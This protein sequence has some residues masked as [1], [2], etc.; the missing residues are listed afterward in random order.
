MRNRISGSGIFID[1]NGYFH[2]IGVHTGGLGDNVNFNN[3]A[4]VGIKYFIDICK[5]NFYDVPKLSSEIDGVL[6]KYFNKFK[7]TITNEDIISTM[8]DI[9]D[10]D[11]S[12]IINL[13]FCDHSKKCEYQEFYHKCD[14]F[15]FNLLLIITLIKYFNPEISLLEMESKICNLKFRF[16][17][18]E[19][20]IGDSPPI[21][22][23]SF[24]KAINEDYL[25]RRSISEE[26]LVIW[27]SGAMV[28]GNLEVLE[29]SY[30]K[31]IYDIYLSRP[32]NRFHILH[33]RG[34]PSKLRILCIEQVI[35]NINEKNM[36]ELSEYMTFK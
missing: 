5:V 4:G 14:T 31:N 7:E 34:R 32:D 36:N 24:I 13:D 15:R 33:G 19:G 21:N 10:S 22:M 8:Y 20:A 12:N 28:T 6:Y 25:N 29:D 11:F 3:V 30:K 16:I 23:I 2:L 1:D 35:K 26:S 27:G 18:S 9:I 17:C